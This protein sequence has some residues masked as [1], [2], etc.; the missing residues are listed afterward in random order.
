MRVA[1]GV[2]RVDRRE[3][4]IGRDGDLRQ[5]CSDIERGVEAVESAADVGETEVANHEGDTG[6]VLVEGPTTRCELEVVCG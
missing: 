4:D 5:T 1:V 2:V 6:V 3:I